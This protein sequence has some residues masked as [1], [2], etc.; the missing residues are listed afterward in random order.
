MNKQVSKPTKPHRHHSAE[1]KD[2]VVARALSGNEK[3]SCIARE[4]DLYES[5]IYGWIAKHRASQAIN[6]D[7]QDLV[8]ETQRL[9]RENARL[10]EDLA[11]LKK[12]AAYFAKELK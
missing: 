1:F 9:K 11:I 5:L 12:A 8:A 10:Q 3:V 4:L 2:Q 7:S 6:N